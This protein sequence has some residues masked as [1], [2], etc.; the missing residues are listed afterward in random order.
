VLPRL[1]EGPRLSLGDDEAAL[2]VGDPVSVVP[3]MATAVF[4]SRHMSCVVPVV[5]VVPIDCFVEGLPM[6]ERDE[7]RPR[8]GLMGR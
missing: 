7:A 2:E 5:G 3:L 8:R 6:G 4:F 1:R